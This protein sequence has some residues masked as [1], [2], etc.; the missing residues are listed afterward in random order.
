MIENNMIINTRDFGEIEVSK[1]EL[2]TFPDGIFAFEQEREFALISPLNTEDEDVYPKWLQS[3][4][5]LAPCFIVFDPTVVDANYTVTL[6]RAEQKLLKL[7]SDSADINSVTVL[8]IATVPDDFAKT[9]LNMKAPIVI[10]RENNLATQVILPADYD[11]KHPLYIED[12][13]LEEAGEDP[14]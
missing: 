10:N 4:N 6:E 3:A 11:F 13:E 8:V 5:D 1:D 12:E 14:C 9:T 2:I 7:D